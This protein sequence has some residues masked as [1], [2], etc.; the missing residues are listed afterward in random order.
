[1]Y[2]IEK[3]ITYNK[4]V[5]IRVSEEMYEYLS[6]LSKETDRSISTLVRQMILWYRNY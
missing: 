3:K 4:T 5:Q 1:M 2:E 6:E